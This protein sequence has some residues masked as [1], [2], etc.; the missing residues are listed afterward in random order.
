M[1]W[2]LV[3]MKRIVLVRMHAGQ[4]KKGSDCSELSEF[5]TLYYRQFRYSS[6]IGWGPTA[7]RVLPSHFE[8]LSATFLQLESLYICVTKSIRSSPPTMT[9]PINTLAIRQTINRLVLI[10]LLGLPLVTYAQDKQPRGQE[11]QSAPEITIRTT[12]RLVLLDIVATDEKGNFVKDLKAE[13]VQVLENG[14]EQNKRDFS[15]QQPD[16]QQ[17]VE[18]L[19]PHLPPNVFTNVPQFKG[20]SSYNIIL[21]DVLNTSFPNLAYAH[22]QLIKYLDESPP[23]QPTA[24]Y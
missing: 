15:F 1:R 20:N 21:L 22:D 9:Q 12:T 14:K 19:Q 13:E 17:A 4:Q 23:N 11:S 18:H 16:A 7:L 6:G 3:P 8:T 5:A 10:V 2:S 24:I